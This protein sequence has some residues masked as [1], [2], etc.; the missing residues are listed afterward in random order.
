MLQRFLEC[1]GLQIS[2]AGMVFRK[3]KISTVDDTMLEG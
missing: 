2:N 1:M 3:E